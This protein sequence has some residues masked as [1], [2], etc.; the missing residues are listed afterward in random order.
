MRIRSITIDFLIYLNKDLMKKT[1]FIIEFVGIEKLLQSSDGK[2]N[3]TQSEVFN[4]C[5]D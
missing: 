5:L 2:A 1:Y 3:L 4:D